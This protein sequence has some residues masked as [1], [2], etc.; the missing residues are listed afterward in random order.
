MGSSKNLPTPRE[1]RARIFR[2][3]LKLVNMSSQQT[4]HLTAFV[5]VFTAVVRKC[6]DEVYTPAAV[7]DGIYGT[8]NIGAVSHINMQSKCSLYFGSE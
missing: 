2:P 4:F 8:R 6:E 3:S 1:T 5:F 7:V